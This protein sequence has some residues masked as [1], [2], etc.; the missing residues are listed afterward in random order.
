MDRTQKGPDSE[1]SIE[2]N[3]LNLL[4]K[5]VNEIWIALG[6]EG[7]KRPDIEKQNKVFRRSLYFVKDLKKGS[8]IKKDDIKRIRPG[9]GIPPK[10]EDFIIGKRVKRNI[11]RGDP[12]KWELVH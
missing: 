3:D 5:E 10:Y 8:I 12:V 2:P 9:F 6:K 4:K 11:S 1:F 7:E